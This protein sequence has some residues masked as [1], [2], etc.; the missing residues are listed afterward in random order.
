[1]SNG[2]AGGDISKIINA[3]PADLSNK[4]WQAAIDSE[5]GIYSPLLKTDTEFRAMGLLG[6][7]LNISG[8]KGSISGDAG[9]KEVTMLNF[10]ER[11]K[12][13]FEKKIGREL[14]FLPS[15]SF[16]KLRGDIMLKLIEKQSNRALDY[17]LVSLGALKPWARRMNN[18]INTLETQKLSNKSELVSQIKSVLKERP[19]LKRELEGRWKTSVNKYNRGDRKNQLSPTEYRERV[20]MYLE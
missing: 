17:T 1:M 8:D 16:G 3:N 7:T 18:V 2:S 15:N 14:E 5:K 20:K 10:L 13:F 11:N 4:E 12:E 19:S 6:P 9:M